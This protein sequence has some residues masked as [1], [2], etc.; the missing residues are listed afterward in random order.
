MERYYGRQALADAAGV[1]VETISAYRSRALLPPPD[2]VIEEGDVATWGWAM[3]TIEQWARDRRSRIGRPPRIR[4][5]NDTHTGECII[6]TQATEA[7][8]YQ[9]LRGTVRAPVEYARQLA[10]APAN[11][12]RCRKFGR[13]I[14]KRIPPLAAVP[15]NVLRADALARASAHGITCAGAPLEDVLAVIAWAER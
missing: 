10:M 9:W 12:R 6:L 3:D 7:D 14:E 1:S 8:V 5:A 11:R 4:I 15:S 2:V 13:I